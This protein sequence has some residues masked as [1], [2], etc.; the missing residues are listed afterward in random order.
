MIPN[1]KG[2]ARDEPPHRGQNPLDSPTSQAMIEIWSC[3][4]HTS[5]ISDSAHTAAAGFLPLSNV[6]TVKLLDP[7]ICLWDDVIEGGDDVGSRCHTPREYADGRSKQ[8]ALTGRAVAQ[9]LARGAHGS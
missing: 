2:K 4:R 9:G 5:E 1:A 7:Q 8:V 6:H 3:G